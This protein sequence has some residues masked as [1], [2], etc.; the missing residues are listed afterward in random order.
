MFHDIKCAVLQSNS[1]KIILIRLTSFVAFREPD[2]EHISAKFCH[3][4]NNVDR[5]NKTLQYAVNSALLPLGYNLTSFKNIVFLH[6]CVIHLKMYLGRNMGSVVLVSYRVSFSGQ[7]FPRNKW[8][9]FL[10]SKIR[11]NFF[12]LRRGFCLMCWPSL[13]NPWPESRPLYME[14]SHRIPL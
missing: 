4:W 3:S 14:G 12:P 10:L 6:L 7:V 1:K 11:E 9:W 5:T 13:W 2:C 8:S